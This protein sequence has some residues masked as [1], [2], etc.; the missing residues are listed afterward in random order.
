MPSPHQK[1]PGELSPSLEHYLRSIYDLQEEKGYARV[2]DIAEKLGV[3]KPAVSAALKTLRTTGLVDHRVYESVLL[4][5]K[6]KERAKSV[7][8]K[9]SI[10]FQFLTEV[11]GVEEEQA[12]VDAILEVR[13]LIQSMLSP[14][15]SVLLDELLP[16][17]GVSGATTSTLSLLNS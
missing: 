4:T 14:Y 15:L 16:A 8:G 13:F 10:L 7:S 2:T 6:G 1:P 11:L 5:E 3:A 9:F 17:G 12:F